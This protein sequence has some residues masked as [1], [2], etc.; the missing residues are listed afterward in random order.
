MTFEDDDEL[1][2]EDIEAHQTIDTKDALFRYLDS[3][4]TEQERQELIEDTAGDMHYSYGLWIRN[5]IIYPGIVDYKNLGHKEKRQEELNLDSLSDNLFEFPLVICGADTESD[6][7]LK[8]F[9]AW[10]REKK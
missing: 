3:K 4:L 5:L 2:Q 6:E 8:D 9:Q 10:L 1:P 7:I